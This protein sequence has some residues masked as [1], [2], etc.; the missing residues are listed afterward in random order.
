M[1]LGIAL[2]THC[3]QASAP[4]ESI[5]DTKHAR[6]EES[7]LSQSPVT[8]LLVA[9]VLERI[10]GEEVTGIVTGAKVG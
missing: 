6:A 10:V 7:L 8:G 2:F 4:L 5:S 9:D 3:V 1:V